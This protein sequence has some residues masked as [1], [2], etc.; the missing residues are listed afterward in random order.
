MFL[1]AVI[2]RPWELS[3]GVCS[4]LK[5]R[6]DSASLGHALERIQLV[7]V[8]GRRRYNLFILEAFWVYRALGN[9]ISSIVSNSHFGKR[10][11]IRDM[12]IYRSHFLANNSNI[13]RGPY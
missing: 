1:F 9:M 5:L 13:V 11:V 12:T 8:S 7:N 2:P 6:R 10:S 4:P 3:G